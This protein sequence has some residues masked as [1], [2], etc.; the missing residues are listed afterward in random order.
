M[1]ANARLLLELRPP[2]PV[3]ATCHKCFLFE[4]CGGLRNGRPLLNCFE[5]FCCDDQSAI[6]CALTSRKI[7]SGECGRSV[8]LL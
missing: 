5:Q 3:S 2:G 4:P 6:M 7:F 1:K 8:A